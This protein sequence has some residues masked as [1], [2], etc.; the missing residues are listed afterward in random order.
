MQVSYSA[1]VVYPGG[2]VGGGMFGGSEIGPICAS[3]YGGGGI[4][5]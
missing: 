5:G 2:V 4:G 1:S 3:Y